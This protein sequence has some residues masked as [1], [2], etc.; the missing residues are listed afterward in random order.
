MSSLSSVPYVSSSFVVPKT[1][2]GVQNYIKMEN[3]RIP[4]RKNGQ[5]KEIIA[6]NGPTVNTPTLYCKKLKNNNI[7]SRLPNKMIY[8]VYKKFFRI[9]LT[10]FLLRSPKKL[11]LLK[12]CTASILHQSLHFFENRLRIM[13]SSPVFFIIADCVFITKDIGGPHR[14]SVRCSIMVTYISKSESAPERCRE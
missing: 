3:W 10:L 12:I 8:C 7:A 2:N 13:C 4:L 11:H 1:I 9:K 14:Q 6:L 5:S